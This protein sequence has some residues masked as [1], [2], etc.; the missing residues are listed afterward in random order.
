MLDDVLL[1]DPGSKYAANKILI[2]LL[3]ISMEVTVYCE[4]AAQYIF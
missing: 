3:T 2:C 4:S 1:A